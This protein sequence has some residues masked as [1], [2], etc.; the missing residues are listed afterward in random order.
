[1][2][3]IIN[4]NV[5]AMK[6]ARHLGTIYDRLGQSVERLSSGLRINTAKD[7]A[8]GL[9]IRELMRADIAATYQGVRNAADALSLVQTADGALAVIDAKLIHMKEL[10]EQATNAILST[11]ERELVNSEYQAMA[12]EIDRIA[13]STNF[14]GVKLLDGSLSSYNQG[15]GLMVHF[16][17]NNTYLEDYYFIKSDDARATSTQGL[18]IGGDGKTDVFSTGAYSGLANG[19]TLGCCGGGFT[20]LKEVI[21]NNVSGSFFYGYNWDGEETSATN[22]LNAKYLAGRYNPG[23]SATLSDLVDQINLGTQSRVGININ[24]TLNSAN[25]Y[26]IIRLGDTEAY[27]VATA[28]DSTT[29]RAAANVTGL[30]KVFSGTSTFLTKAINVSSQ[31]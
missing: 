12:A 15:K 6:A 1:M 3:L 16:G 2:S 18:R 13:N 29:A 17:I 4:H 14:N 28:G 30:T 9:A 21:Q 22:L 11:L 24:G 8:A 20:G 10:A 23:K 7:D 5:P 25:G 19:K 27:I 31:N 26:T